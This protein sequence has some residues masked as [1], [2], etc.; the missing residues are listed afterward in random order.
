MRSLLIF[1]FLMLRKTEYKS[2]AP[3]VHPT[4]NVI[5]NRKN[6]A[7]NIPN[8][9]AI[10]SKTAC[11]AVKQIHII[12]SLLKRRGGGLVRPPPQGADYV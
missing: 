5:P 10:C 4:E 6:R 2:F 7:A 3:D 11:E 9:F 8:C 12:K 1:L